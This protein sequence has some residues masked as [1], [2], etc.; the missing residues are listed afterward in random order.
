MTASLPR[1]TD[2]EIERVIDAMIPEIRQSLKTVMQEHN[3]VDS[4]DCGTGTNSTGAKTRYVCF[5]AHEFAALIFEGTMK[6]MAD[7]MKAQM[8]LYRSVAGEKG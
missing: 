1:A 3:P 2:A 6:G 5:I 4:F 7:S 8:E